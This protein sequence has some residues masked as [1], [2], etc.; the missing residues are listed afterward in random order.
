VITDCATIP[1]K[2]IRFSKASRL[3]WPRLSGCPEA[4]MGSMLSGDAESLACRDHFFSRT[5]ME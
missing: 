2:W 4:V 1:K 5:T 3:P